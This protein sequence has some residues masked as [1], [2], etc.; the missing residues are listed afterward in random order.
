MRAQ[1]PFLGHIASRQGVRVDPAKMEAVENWL[2]PT[3]VKDVRAF[4]GLAS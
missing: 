2:T 3:N 1:V 4:L